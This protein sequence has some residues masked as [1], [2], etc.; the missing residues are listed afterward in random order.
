VSEV[1]NKDEIKEL[2][3]LGKKI[4]AELSCD[5]NDQGIPCRTGR[6]TVIEMMKD[7]LKIHNYE[8]L[9]IY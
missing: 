1:L 7:Y 9:G 8:I 6:F 5:I 4:Q 2:A 3:R